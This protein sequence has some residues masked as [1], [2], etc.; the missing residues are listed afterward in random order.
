MFELGQ[1]V[2]HKSD[3]DQA[4]PLVI[5]QVPLFEGEN[6][7]VE[8]YVE[9]ELKGAGMRGEVLILPQEKVESE[10]LIES[11]S[12]LKASEKDFY[13]LKEYGSLLAN[14]FYDAGDSEAEKATRFVYNF[15][16]YGKNRDLV[17]KLLNICKMLFECETIVSIPAHDLYPNEL[18]K[19]FGEVIKRISPVETRKY[20]HAKAIDLDYAKSYVIDYQK[21]K[22]KILLIDDIAQSGKTLDHFASVLE[23]AGFEVVKF[24]LGLE[25][26]LRPI[27]FQKVFVG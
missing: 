27:L 5:S 8:W 15:K 25:K 18:Q 17:G 10:S 21:I 1:I 22:G 11:Y 13:G 14:S 19:M 23:G 7:A 4:N 12:I 26:K 16:K 24:A 2:Y 9:G 20:S 6:Y 3:L